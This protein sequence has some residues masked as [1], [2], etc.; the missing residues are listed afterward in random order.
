MIDDLYRGSPVYRQLHSK[1][2]F[3]LYKEG[4]NTFVSETVGDNKNAWL[5]RVVSDQN[6]QTWE[7]RYDDSST[8]RWHPCTSLVCVEGIIECCQSLTVVCDTIPAISGTYTPV[9]GTYSWGRLVYT[10]QGGTHNIKV[11]GYYHN[12]WTISQGD[13]TVLY[14]RYASI[15]PCDWLA[16]WSD[17]EGRH[18]WARD[19][20]GGDKIVLSMTCD[21]HHTQESHQQPEYWDQ[22]NQ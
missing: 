8:W 12:V 13:K 10:Q 7:Y 2:S 18:T 17:Q 20:L 21:T 1:H 6:S 11:G 14:S 5:R 4:D 19:I 9:Q 15:N 16:G 3:Y 22:D